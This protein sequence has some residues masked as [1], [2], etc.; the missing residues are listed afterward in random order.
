MY[1]KTEQKMTTLKILFL[2]AH[3]IPTN[4]KYQTVQTPQRE[5]NG[6]KKK[7]IKAMLA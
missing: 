6:K 5:G 3:V 4:N 2:L 1:K 7:G